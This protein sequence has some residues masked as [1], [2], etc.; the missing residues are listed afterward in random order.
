[1]T[2]WFLDSEFNEDG[3][4]IDLISIA[5]VADDGR[6]YYAVSSEFDAEYCNDWVKANVLPRLGASERKSRAQIAKEIVALVLGSDTPLAGQERLSKPS[7]WGYF[8]DY[9]WV[10]FCQ[11]FGK[12]IDLPKGMPMYCNDV[13]QLMHMTGLTRAELDLH[14]AQTNEHNAL[15][16]A[17][18]IRDA[19]R[20]ITERFRIT[21]L[22][23]EF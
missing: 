11:L 15:S 10:L 21:R 23:P 17:R 14:I 1:M 16:D 3:V 9:D 19:H 5:L 7:F 4:T 2:L 8:A 20:Y 6:E 18:W 12:M 13:K 22:A